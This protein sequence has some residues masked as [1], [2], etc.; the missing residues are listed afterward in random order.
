MMPNL[1]KK[2]VRSRRNGDGPSEVTRHISV[3]TQCMLWGKA[4]GRCE[5]AGCNGP[6]WKSPVTQEPVNI[7][8]K[9]HI[10]AFS[11]A[12]PRG[13]RGLKASE[14]N[15]VSNLMLVCHSCHRKIDQASDGGRYSAELLRQWK[16]SHEERVERVTAI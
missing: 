4:A 7:A 16:S 13:R 3:S 5:F 11:S 9:A 10:Y 1:P 12:G 2:P 15:D 14:I 6:L 8:Q